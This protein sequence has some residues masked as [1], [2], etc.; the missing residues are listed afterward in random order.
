MYGSEYIGDEAR[1]KKLKRIQM[2]Q[3]SWRRSSA[4]G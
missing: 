4:C 1:K 3:G 2:R